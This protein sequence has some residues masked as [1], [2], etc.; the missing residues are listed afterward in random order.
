LSWKFLSSGRSG[1]A[2]LGERVAAVERGGLRLVVGGEAGIGVDALLDRLQEFGV[3]RAQRVFGED[4]RRRRY[5]EER[6]EGQKKHTKQ[7]GMDRSG[8]G[9]G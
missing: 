5:G 7:I 1:V 2:G 4:Q 6:H 3:L 9:H 8:E